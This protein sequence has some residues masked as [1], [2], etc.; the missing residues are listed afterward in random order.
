MEKD[1]FDDVFRTEYVVKDGHKMPLS[2]FDRPDEY[3]ARHQQQTYTGEQYARMLKF[4][5][6]GTAMFDKRWKS[7]KEVIDQVAREVNIDPEKTGL[8][9]YGVGCGED[10]PLV[11]EMRKWFDKSGD[12]VKMKKRIAD[13]EAQVETLKAL[14]I[15]GG[16][17]P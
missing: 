2:D 5:D 7:A 17:T 4:K 15:S 11:A 12:K 13:L 6:R 16:G 1:I 9:L 14:L 10:T 8:Y 3:Y